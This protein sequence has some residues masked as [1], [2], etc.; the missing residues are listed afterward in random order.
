MKRFLTIALV[1]GAALATMPAE[2]RG[3]FYGPHAGFAI[4]FGP[5]GCWGCAYYPPYYGPA[6]YPPYYYGPPYPPPPSYR[7]DAGQ[8]WNVTHQRDETDFE[9]PDN[10]LFALDSANIS[11]DAD[12]II[13][14]IA[15]AARNEPNATL[16]VEGH[17]DT[18]GGRAH[19]QQLSQ[20]RAQAVEDVLVRQGVSRARIR[21]E[22]LGEAGL[23][24]QTGDGVREL[25]NRRVVVR[26]MHAA[27]SDHR[28]YQNNQPIGDG[29]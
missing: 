5:P 17:T 28:A 16:I 18:S 24:V 7:P 14:E 11:K 26:L 12:A 4:G 3:F 8:Q 20:A 15:T 19:N 22:G 2:A 29:R 1:A 25:R 9:L 27:G 13:S 23:A 6:W 21:A 10:V